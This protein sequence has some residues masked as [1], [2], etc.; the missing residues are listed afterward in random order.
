MSVRRAGCGVL[1]W[2][3]PVGGGQGL[4]YK[5]RFYRG[6][7]FATTPASLRRVLASPTNSLTFTAQD[8][9]SARPLYAIVS[10]Q[11][12]FFYVLGITH[13]YLWLS[14]THNFVLVCIR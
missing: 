5:I 6:Q 4:T 10:F 12:L 14:N 9:P 3:P 13:S 1:E 11:S 2:D 7:S 8:V